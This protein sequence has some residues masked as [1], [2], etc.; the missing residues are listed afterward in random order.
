MNAFL[1]SRTVPYFENLRINFFRHI[2]ELTLW[3]SQN[4]LIPDIAPIPEP[5][6]PQNII[7]IPDEPIHNNKTRDSRHESDNEVS[8][9]VADEV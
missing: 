8:D 7:L 1:M 6:A 4:N 9:V 2:T 3:D 5:P